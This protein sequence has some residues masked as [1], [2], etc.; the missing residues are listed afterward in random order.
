MDG[1][2]G[3]GGQVNRGDDLSLGV[4]E[5][6]EDLLGITVQS[7]FAAI[8]VL[9]TGKDLFE[10]RDIVAEIPI[11]DMPVSPQVALKELIFREIGCPEL[12]PEGQKPEKDDL[13]G[14]ADPGGGNEIRG[15]AA[16]DEQKL[17]Q[18]RRP[19]FDD[20]SQ[21]DGQTSVLIIIGEAFQFRIYLLTFEKCENPVF[22]VRERRDRQDFLPSPQAGFE[23]GKFFLDGLGLPAQPPEVL[24]EIA[25]RQ[26][27]RQKGGEAQEGKGED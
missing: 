26:Q 25:G 18:R 24:L 10:P 5:R 20:I 11:I 12:G 14:L 19:E 2:K 15:G 27:S 1:A 4:P 13:L 21:P 16:A 9:V 7:G 3:R 17:V 23:K 22:I 8:F 6:E